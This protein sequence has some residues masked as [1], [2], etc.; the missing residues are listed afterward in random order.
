MWMPAIGFALN[1]VLMLLVV[2]TGALALV[3]RWQRRQGRTSDAKPWWV[4][5]GAE[6][7]TVIALVFGCRV[8]VADWMRVP[9]GSMEPAVRVGD[10]LL[11]NHW[12]YGPRLPFTNTALPLGEPRRGDVVVFRH[13]REVSTF[14]VKRLVALPGDHVRFR[15]GVVAVNGEPF[16][17]RP[18]GPGTRAEDLGEWFVSETSAGVSRILKL[19]PAV[20]GRSPLAMEPGCV[21]QGPAAWECTVPE[22]HALMLGDHR[23]DSADSRYWGFLPMREIYGKAERVLV[24]FSE[25]SRTWQRL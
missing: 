20:M 11:I 21:S 6:F 7:F 19:H 8:A 16:T 10:V 12:A 5:W 23:D 13:P 4:S 9:T 2:L 15:D 14:L 22:G 18:V 1:E 3:W 25:P 24:N 17:A